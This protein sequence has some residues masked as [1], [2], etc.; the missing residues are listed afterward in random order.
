MSAPFTDIVR[1]AALIKAGKLHSYVDGERDRYFRAEDL[2]CR[3]SFYRTRHLMM[4]ILGID[5][6]DLDQKHLIGELEW[7]DNKKN[8]SVVGVDCGTGPV[9]F[10]ERNGK[11]YAESYE[12]NAGS[13]KEA[14]VT[15]LDSLHDFL[16]RYPPYG[17]HVTEDGDD[18]HIGI[19]DD[20]LACNP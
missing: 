1:D 17:W 5:P 6:L 9:F 10:S 13:P 2:R 7:V 19:L 11:L 16:R 20:C 14:M 8:G 4:T 15:S 3:A 12:D 18:E